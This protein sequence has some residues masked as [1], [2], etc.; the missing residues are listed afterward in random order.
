MLKLLRPIQQLLHFILGR[1]QA[2]LDLISLIT[3][4]GM[5]HNLA[6]TCQHL[7]T[8]QVHNNQ[9]SASSKSHPNGRL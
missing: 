4:R 6:K 5:L 8:T 9:H 1:K 2:I 7:D 3:N